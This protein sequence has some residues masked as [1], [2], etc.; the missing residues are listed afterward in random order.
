[1]NLIDTFY[2]SDEEIS[3]LDRVERIKARFQKEKISKLIRRYDVS[4]INFN[5]NGNYINGT[6]ANNKSFTW[7]PNNGMEIR[8]RYCGTLVIDG[9]TIFTS[10][11]IQK[12]IPY[13]F[14]D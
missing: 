10:G 8:S 2:M 9:K 3:S 12:A 6:T 7:Y 4:K 1:M 5:K 13:L 14:D 11:T